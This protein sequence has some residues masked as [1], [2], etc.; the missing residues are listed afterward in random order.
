MIHAPPIKPLHEMTLLQYKQHIVSTIRTEY[1]CSTEEATDCY[2]LQGGDNAYYKLLA[3][4][5]ENAVTLA[6]RQ[7]DDLYLH[8]EAKAGTRDAVNY[9]CK[10]PQGF[11]DKW[12]NST[13]RRRQAEARTHH[14]ATMREE[15]LALKE[16]L[17]R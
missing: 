15:R 11:P 4:A 8:I 12:L 6:T 17:S 5:V 2:G 9:V 3:Q 1:G 7:A 10:Y 13:E 14:K 16:K